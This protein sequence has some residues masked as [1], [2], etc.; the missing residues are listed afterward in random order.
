[1][2][3]LSR[4]HTLL[5][6]KFN[7]VAHHLICVTRE[8]EQ[9]TEPL[10]AAD[11]EATWAAMQVTNVTQSQRCVLCALFSIA[12]T[13]GARCASKSRSRCSL[14]YPKADSIRLVMSMSLWPSFFPREHSWHGHTA[15]IPCCIS[16]CR[17]LGPSPP[18]RWLPRHEQAFPN[19]A[20]AY[21]NCGG[22]AGASQPHK[23]T[24]IVPLPL[25]ESSG[26]TGSPFEGAVLEAC[27]QAG[28]Q[29][30]RAVPLRSL[31]YQ[32]YAAV[33]GDRYVQPV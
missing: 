30:A 13:G 24:Q 25:A 4:T 17:V 3:H 22:E 12:F 6:N 28:A 5:L 14:A 21:F 32:C 20:L 27:Q 26:C 31:P 9:Q 18:S 23:H 2:R 33:L 16:P 10:N 29:Q 15:C 8:F 11:L 1:M 7:V 19:G